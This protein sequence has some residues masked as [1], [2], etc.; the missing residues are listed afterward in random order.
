MRAVS[1]TV[2]VNLTSLQLT[3]DSY[4]GAGSLGLPLFRHRFYN[5]FFCFNSLPHN[6]VKL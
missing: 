1:L 2:H 6:Q 5:V 4:L 3:T